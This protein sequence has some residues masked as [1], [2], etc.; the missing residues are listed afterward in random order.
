MHR[1][2]KVIAISLLLCSF[3]Q[4][5]RAEEYFDVNLVSGTS[6]VEALRAIS[7]RANKD[8]VI[9]GEVA[10]T[11]SL[12]LV[13][14]TFNDALNC[15]AMVSGFTYMTNGNVILISPVDKMSKVETY[16]IKHLDLEQLKKEVGTFVP[17]E[18]ISVDADQSTMTVDGTT[19]QLT[20][21]SEFLH[22]ADVAQKQITVQVNVLEV[23]RSKT[24][25]MGLDYTVGQYAKGYQGIMWAVTPNYEENQS[26]GNVL[27]SPSVTVFNGKK[28]KLLIGDKVPVFTSTQESSLDGST[29]SLDRT[30]TVKYE[31]VGVKLEVTPRVNDDDLGTVSV[32]IKPSVSSISG[33]W[34]TQNNRAPQIATREVETE[35]RVKTGETIYI[36]GLLK[37]SDIKSIKA[38]PFLSKLPI[39]GELFKK[40]SITKEK[41]EVII[42]LTPRIVNDINGAP[43]FAPPNNAQRVKQG[44]RNAK[45]KYAQNNKEMLDY[46]QREVEKKQPKDKRATKNLSELNESKAAS[47]P[48]KFKKA[49]L[50][51][52]AMQQK[53]NLELNEKADTQN[54]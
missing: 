37:D 1:L 53:L 21:V 41:T 32:K 20:K 12:S 26:I 38:I 25:E 4:G 42:A 23:D 27:A 24:R 16:R 31:E 51:Q 48:G 46:F 49:W 15:L 34:E 10:G 43:E 50:R 11:I 36:G 22:K 47:E 39:L 7:M 3:N 19:T 40:R 17:K 8:I 35:L 28:A 5:V 6:V 52:K 33:W 45:Q 9:N 18:K 54:E 2:K 30:I 14:T 44:L 13:H 29:A